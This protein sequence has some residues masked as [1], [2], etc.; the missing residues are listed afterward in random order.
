MKYI[1]ADL[2]RKEIKR[3]MDKHWDLLPNAD[4]PEDDWTHNELCELGA[5]KELEHLEQF[6]DSLQ[7]EQP[8][9]EE[10]TI[11]VG[12]HTHTL[13]VGSQSDIDNLIRQEK[14]KQPEVD[15]E[16]EEFVGVAESPLKTFPRVNDFECGGSYRH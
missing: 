13:R 10:Y 2:L 11:E 8:I 15:L 1:D 4:S 12:K 14:Q 16:K 5:F 7:Q 3:R 9:G 6:L